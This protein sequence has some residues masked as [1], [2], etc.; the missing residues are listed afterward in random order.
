M[1]NSDVKC[2]IRNLI[3][4]IARNNKKLNHNFTKID[5]IEYLIYFKIDMIYR[6]VQFNEPS[7][8]SHN[9]PNIKNSNLYEYFKSNR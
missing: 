6:S 5:G 7:S 9:L 8:A 4:F 1:D 2:K 3:I